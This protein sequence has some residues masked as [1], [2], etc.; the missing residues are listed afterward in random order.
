VSDDEDPYRF[1]VF[2][3]A[4]CYEDDAEHAADCPSVTGVFPVR[5]Q[6]FGPTCVHCGKGAFGGMRCS[7]CGAA[8]RLGDHYMHRE[9][10][11]GDPSVPGIAGASVQMVICVGCA[12]KDAFARTRPDQ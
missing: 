12:A 5:E 3:N 1:C 6:D 10:E 7:D 11:P 8:L 4:D 9:V 2:C